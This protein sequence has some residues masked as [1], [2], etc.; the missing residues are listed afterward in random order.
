VKLRRVQYIYNN[1]PHQTGTF[2]FHGFFMIEGEVK[3][4]VENGKGEMEWIEMY[5][6]RFIDSPDT[7]GD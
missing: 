2:Y 5:R 6:L 7:G 4:L 3:A 1:Q